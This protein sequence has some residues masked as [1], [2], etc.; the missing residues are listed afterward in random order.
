MQNDYKETQTSYKEIIIRKTK[1]Y[2]KKNDAKL[3]KDNI[4]M[5][6]NANKCTTTNKDIITG[7]CKINTNYARDTTTT[8]RIKLKR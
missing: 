1:D 5:Q 3:P 4:K 6:I 2:F 7:R 8:K